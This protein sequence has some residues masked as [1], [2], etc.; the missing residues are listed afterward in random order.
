MFCGYLNK[1][2]SLFTNFQYDIKAFFELKGIKRSNDKL[3]ETYS[4]IKV[5]TQ[6]TPDQKVI[7][8]AFIPSQEELF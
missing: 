1:F 8:S 5:Q 2:F 7:K 6:I 4:Y 3:L